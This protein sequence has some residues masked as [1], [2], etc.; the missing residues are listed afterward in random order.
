MIQILHSMTLHEAR[1]LEVATFRSL[2]SV[3]SKNHR[4][5]SGVAAATSIP[6]RNESR[7]F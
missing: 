5:L 2:G 3:Q 6:L 7:L 1:L 4:Q